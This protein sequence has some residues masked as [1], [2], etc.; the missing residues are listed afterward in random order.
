MIVA[1]ESGQICHVPARYYIQVQAQPNI[2]IKINIKININTNSINK[3]NPSTIFTNNARTN[4]FI[5]F[6]NK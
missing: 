5:N 2:T 6:L 3:K 4:T 1:Y